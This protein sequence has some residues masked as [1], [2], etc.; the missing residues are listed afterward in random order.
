MKRNGRPWRK[1]LLLLGG[2]LLLA[3]AARVGSRLV[4]ADAIRPGDRG[5]INVFVSVLP[6]KYFVERIGGERVSVTVMVGPGQNPATYEPLPQQMRA[7]TEADLYFRIGVPFETAWIDRLQALNRELIMVDTREGVALREMEQ[8]CH[9]SEAE[10][11][12]LHAHGHHGEGLLDPHIWLDPLLVKIQ[13]ETVYRALAAFDPGARDYYQANLARFHADLDQLHTE[14]QAT[15]DRLKVKT[16]MVY[17]P[18]WG[19]LADRYG[20]KQVALE[21]EGKEPGPRKL[22]QLIDYAKAEGIRVI[23]IQSQFNSAAAEAVARAVNGQVVSIDP[24]AEDYLT[25]MRRIAQAIK[26][27]Y[28]TSGESN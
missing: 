27:S 17:H 23:F 8:A 11:A 4:T 15:F 18:A 26:G 28:D 13:A 12:D 1:L 2:G 3:V 19:Y 14:L 10:T 5:K 7:L 20:L 21:V 25:N 22:A 9:G 24:L 16:L 6:Q